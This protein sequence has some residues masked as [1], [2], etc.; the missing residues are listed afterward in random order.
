MDYFLKEVEENY[1]TSYQFLLW[2][3]KNMELDFLFLENLCVPKEIKDF[4]RSDLLFK[5]VK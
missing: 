5:S 1:L 2:G 3:P 4:L